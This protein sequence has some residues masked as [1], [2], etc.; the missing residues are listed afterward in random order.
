[1]LGL[2]AESRPF[3]FNHSRACEAAFT[4]E[5]FFLGCTE[6]GLFLPE[7]FLKHNASVAS[8]EYETR[9]RESGEC[10]MES[11]GDLKSCV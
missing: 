5:G 2:N 6:A 9:Q 10:N 1:M 4:C 11:F 3:S 7:I 8:G